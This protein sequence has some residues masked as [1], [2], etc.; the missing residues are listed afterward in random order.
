M[1]DRDDFILGDRPAEPAR[2]AGP[3]PRPGMSPYA[4]GPTTRGPGLSGCAIAAIIGGIVVVG[5]AFVAILAALLFPVFQQAR[6]KARQASG[7]PGL[8]VKEPEFGVQY[9]LP[10]RFP[11]PEREKERQAEGGVRYWTLSLSSSPPLGD[12]FCLVQV[13]YFPD[14]L[15]DDYA[16]EA[17][18]K[19]SAEE[20]RESLSGKRTRADLTTVAG[21]PAYDSW[22]EA[23]PEGESQLYRYRVR[24]LHTQDRIIQ[25]WFGSPQPNRLDGRPAQN[26]FDSIRISPV[27]ASLKRAR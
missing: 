25:L 9:T 6:E 19:G 15:Q 7:A 2:P 21:R 13:N 4:Q 24:I 20:A 5:L 10:Y 17:A 26:F 3:P 14:G 8:A 1:N 27:S 22:F 16:T 12:D 23:T 11:K 18:L